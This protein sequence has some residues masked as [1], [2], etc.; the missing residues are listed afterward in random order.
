MGLLEKFKFPPKPDA[1][2]P[3][4][5]IVVPLDIKPMIIPYFTPYILIVPLSIFPELYLNCT[6]VT[7]DVVFP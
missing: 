6:P 7:A 1:I 4:S 2:E 3:L 5:N